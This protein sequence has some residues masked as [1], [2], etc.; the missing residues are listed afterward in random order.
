VDAPGNS[1]ENFYVGSI[2]LNGRKFDR[3]YITHYELR[4]GGKLTFN[5][6]AEP[7]YERGTDEAAFPYSMSTEN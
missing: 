3:N 6:S 4:R 7:D 5:M 1:R 2:N